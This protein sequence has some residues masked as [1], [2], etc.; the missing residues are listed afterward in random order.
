MFYSMFFVMCLFAPLVLNKHALH[1][2]RHY[3]CLTTMEHQAPPSLNIYP[4][5]FSP[6]SL[7]EM[8]W[9]SRKVLEKCDRLVKPS[10]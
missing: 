10:A 1:T 3:K 2:H 5:F 9:N 4:L 7:G 6:Y 8:P